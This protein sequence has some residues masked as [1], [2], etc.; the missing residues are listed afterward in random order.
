MVGV[1]ANGFPLLFMTRVFELGRR[2]GRSVM[3]L[4]LVVFCRK[5][6]D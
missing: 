2:E 1:T 6:E 4:S 3:K 5:C